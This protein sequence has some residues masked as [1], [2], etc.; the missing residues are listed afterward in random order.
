MRV[1]L[2]EEEQQFTSFQD[3]DDWL[4]AVKNLVLICQT[5]GCFNNASTNV[6]LSRS[7]NQISILQPFFQKYGIHIKL[8]QKVPKQLCNISVDFVLLCTL[9][10]DFTSPTDIFFFQDLIVNVIPV[11]SPKIFLCGKLSLSMN[12]WL[13]VVLFSSAKTCHFCCHPA[14]VLLTAVAESAS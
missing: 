8:I 1:K 9:K 11:G 5:R 14:K 12:H 2:P 3:R 13:M 6:K 10:S 4:L 7:K